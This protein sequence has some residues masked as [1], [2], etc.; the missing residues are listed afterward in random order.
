MEKVNDNTYKS[1]ERI[2]LNALDIYAPLKTKMLRF[3]ESAFMTKKLRKEIMTRSKLKNNFNMNRNHENWCKYKTQRNYWLNLLRKSKK[4]Y[5]SNLNVNDVTDSKTFW[6]YVKP[7][8]N[9]KGSNSNKNTLVEND[10]IITIDR[11]ISKIMNA[12]H[13]NATENLK[14][15]PLK[16]SSDTDINQIKSVFKNHVSIRKIQECFPN[17]EANDFN[18]RQV[19]VKDKML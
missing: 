11:V 8:F 18:F 12:F 17:I 6:K 10:V 13:V 14:I 16:T 4:Q 5:L 7:N 9:G 3:N 19:S 15:K 1:F 2:F